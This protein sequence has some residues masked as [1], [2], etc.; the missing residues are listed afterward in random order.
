MLNHQPG[1]L[2]AVCLGVPYSYLCS[3]PFVILLHPLQPFEEQ[4][5]VTA[6][7][8][9]LFFLSHLKGI[10]TW[11][12]Q[13]MWP[14]WFILLKHQ[15]WITAA[16]ST[17][18]CPWRHLDASASIKSGT[19]TTIPHMPFKSLFCKFLCN[20]GQRVHTSFK[21]THTSFKKMQLFKKTQLR[22]VKASPD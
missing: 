3:F 12:S 7:K 9:F 5:M 10:L 2:R 6:K 13:L 18:G 16:H 21:K 14:H 11:Q 4:V 8:D 20:T 1:T 19:L 17:W 22:K 15:F